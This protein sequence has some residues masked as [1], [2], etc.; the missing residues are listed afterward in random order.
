MSNMSDHDKIKQ[1]FK[2]ILGNGNKEETFNNF[3][4]NLGKIAKLVEQDNE[5]V[6]KAIKTK[7]NS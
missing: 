1:E 5:L 3:F 6:T 4:A 7:E 2:K